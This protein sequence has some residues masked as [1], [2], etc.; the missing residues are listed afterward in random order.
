[1]NLFK[2]RRVGLSDLM[3]MAVA[4]LISLMCLLPL[5]YIL[6]L[7]LSDKSAATAGLVTFL[8]VDFTWS[9]YTYLLREHGFYLAFMVSVKRVLIGCSINF[10]L[11]ILMAYPLAKEK[12]EFKSRN[13][14]MWVILVTMLFNGGLIPW[15]MVVKSLHL[16]NTIWALTLPLAVPVFNVI[17]LM[18]FFRGL[19][20]EISEAAAIDG[21]GPWR[22]LL[23]IFLPL[24][25]PAVA[26]VTL[27]SFINHW[28]A[29]FDGLILINTQSKIPLQTYIQQLVI[30][31]PNN[32]T[33]PEDI[34]NLLSQRT[35][36]AAKIV[37]TML[38]I[39]LVYPFLQ[40]YFVGG[41]T[42]GSVKE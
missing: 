27:F 19:P 25:L 3:L 41:I 14:Y 16:T 35:T 42:L 1:M 38:P 9:S 24:S 39:L 30:P 5:I 36:N 20:K 29:F 31:Q 2:H 32:L 17:L 18:N 26:T 21:S 40:K 15:Y 12:S 34:V 4:C 33:R 11:T 7:S 37:V 8:P 28:N 23:T 22:L 10:I 13:I 6:S